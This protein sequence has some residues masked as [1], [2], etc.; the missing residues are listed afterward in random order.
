MGARGKKQVR[1]KARGKYREHY[2]M[3]GRVT[4]RERLLEYRMG[5]GWEPLCRVLGKEVP[6]VPF[7]RVNDQ[8]VH[9]EQLR[10]IMKKGLWT[11]ERRVGGW[12]GWLA[13]L[14]AVGLAWW[15]G[16]RWF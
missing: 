13:L 8:E 14:L 6:D 10:I 4:P 15:V 16:R 9:D 11:M 2:E 1:A 3:V 7:P 5:D 12:L